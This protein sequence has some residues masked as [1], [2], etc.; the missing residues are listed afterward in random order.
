VLK[1]GRPGLDSLASQH[2]RQQRGAAARFS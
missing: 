2:G 1:V